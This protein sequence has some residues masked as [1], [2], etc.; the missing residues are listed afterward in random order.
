[1]EG[2]SIY[3]CLTDSFVNELW[4]G[5]HNLETDTFMLALYKSTASL[6]AS[7]TAY[8]SSEEVSGTNYSAGGFTLTVASGCPQLVKPQMIWT[9]DR[10]VV[11][12]V[13]LSDVKAGL[14]YNSSKSDKAVA[15][16]NFGGPRVYT[17]ESF[18]CPFPSVSDGGLLNWN[19]GA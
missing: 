5:E 19:K 13:T 2:V 16:L 15:V 9:F 10:L 3:Q 11:A 12:S 18:I 6:G 8:T 4:R 17:A 14:I 1:M 7:T